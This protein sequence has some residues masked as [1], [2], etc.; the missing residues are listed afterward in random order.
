MSRIRVAAEA[1]IAAQPEAIY[2]IFVDYHAKH[3]HILPAEFRDLEVEAG[4]HGAGTIVRFRTRIAGVE[5]SYRMIVSEPEPGRVLMES[6]TL[7]TLVTTFTVTPIQDGQQTHVQI[8]TELD[9]SSGLSSLFGR[10][11]LPLI[12][13]P[14]YKKE[15]RQLAHLLATD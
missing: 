2:E 8:M 1:I 13:R 9:S 12:M 3:G 7:S 10:M 5:R 6:D 4:G 15:L 14:I 11:L